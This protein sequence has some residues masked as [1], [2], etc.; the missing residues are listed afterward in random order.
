MT[1]KRIVYK[2]LGTITGQTL[3]SDKLINVT[4][5]VHPRPATGPVISHI[6]VLSHILWATLANAPCLTLNQSFSVCLKVLS[7]WLATLYKVHQRERKVYIYKILRQ[8]VNRKN[9][10]TKFR[11]VLS[12]LPV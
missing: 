7:C 5:L 2:S 10:S 11:P 12:P 1:W 6:L 9:N 3:S 8:V 4:I